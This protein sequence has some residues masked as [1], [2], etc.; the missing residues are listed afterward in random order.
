MAFGGLAALALWQFT[1]A[2]ARFD[3]LAFA[4]RW[5]RRLLEIGRGVVYLVLA[6]AVLLVLLGRDPEDAGG[7]ADIT[8]TILRSRG[9]FILIIVAGFGVLAAGVG[10]IVVGIRRSFTKLIRIPTGRSRGI[11]LVLGVIGYLA[12]GL[13]L[14]IFGVVLLVAAITGDASQATGLDGGLRALL[15]IPFGSLLVGLVGVGLALYGVFLII[16]TRLAR[17]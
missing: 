8:A 14:A 4:Q 2:S 1:Q 6:G 3:Q 15:D 11:V 17:L 9:G 7:I 13:G 16:R 5:G 10:F 12:N